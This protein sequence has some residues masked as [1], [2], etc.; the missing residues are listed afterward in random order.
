MFYKGNYWRYRGV[1]GG[2]CSN[3]DLRDGYTNADAVDKS[4][5]SFKDDDFFYTFP[6]TSCSKTYPKYGS[7]WCC[8]IT[9]SINKINQQLNSGEYNT[10]TIN[11]ITLGVWTTQFEDAKKLADEQGIPM[12]LLMTAMP[13]N[14]TSNSFNTTVL[15]NTEF[16]KWRSERPFIWCH[17]NS[18]DGTWNNTKKST[19]KTFMNNTTVPCTGLYW[20]RTNYNNTGIYKDIQIINSN[21][22]L[23]TVE[24]Y[25]NYILN[26]FGNYNSSTRQSSNKQ[27]TS[28]T[29]SSSTV[30][31]TLTTEN[32]TTTE[33]INLSHYLGRYCTTGVNDVTFEK[34]EALANQYNIPLIVFR[35]DFQ[36]CE[37]SQKFN[38]YVLQNDEFKTWVK[39]QNFIVYISSSKSATIQNVDSTNL[40]LT[41]IGRDASKSLF[42][43]SGK[44]IIFC[45]YWT[46]NTILKAYN[47]SSINKKSVA[48]VEN[49]VNHLL[50]NYKPIEYT[51]TDSGEKT[52]I[53]QNNIITNDPIKIDDITLGIWV[54]NQFIKM[55]EI[56]DNYGIPMVLCGELASC[57]NCN[58]FNSA[59]FDNEIFINWCATK[60]Y[61]FSLSKAGWDNDWSSANLAAYLN[62]L[63]RP[64]NKKTLPHFSVYWNRTNYDG[65][66]SIRAQNTIV[67]AT[68]EKC[69][70]EYCQKFIDKYLS[71]FDI[72]KV[73][74]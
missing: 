23:N 52:Y 2:E 5:F 18:S 28:T 64:Y 37:I 74:L 8:D 60:P 70:I 61:L 45:I 69:S 36:S 47:Y 43:Y 49:Q 7:E 19:I 42:N 21:S 40:R 38:T 6:N 12:V 26:Q 24:G 9:T 4:Q 1:T 71:H 73:K 50:K 41:G 11:N 10:K 56:A 30:Q 48:Y 66:S 27:Q 35:G 59:V 13:F 44:Y 29:T 54:K 57:S 62:F 65:G 55:K 34:C 68:G 14:T 20:N 53:I 67:T 31:I 22:S 39:T 16:K 33:T 58:R 46:T 63:G 72:N 51:T 3:I 32:K 15:T 17:I 25:K